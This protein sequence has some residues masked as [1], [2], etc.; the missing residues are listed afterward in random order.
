MPIYE[1]ENTTRD[2]L[3]KLRKRNMCQVCGDKLS[4]FLD[5]DTGK[6]F[7]A[8]SDWLRSHHEGIE[9]ETS[10]YEKEGLASLNIPTR[11]EIMTQD[12]G[13]ETSTAL[14]RLPMSGR[15]TQPEAMHILK[16]VYP[17]VPEDQIIRTAILCRDFGLHPLMKEVY[18]IGFKNKAGGI[19]YS[20]VIG[21][22]ANRK[23][24]ADKKGAY[25]FIDDSP[26]AASKE[27][28]A[29]QYGENSEEG[30]DNLVS[31]CRLK[32]QLGNDAVGF[33]L[34]P[35]NKSPYGTDKGNTP[36][37]MANIRSERQALDRL[38][39]ETLPLRGYE[40]I[41]E[42]Y[43][44]LPDIGKVNT[45]TGEII[46][47]EVTEVADAPKEHWCK[48]HDC[49]FELKAGKYG[50]FYAHKKDGG[51]WCNEKK[52]KETRP[53]P[54]P[55]EANSDQ[56]SEDEP[57]PEPRNTDAIK[58]FNDL[59]KACHEDFKD[60]EGKGMQPDQVISELGVGSQSDISDTPAE[61]YMRI[62]AVRV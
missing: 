60:A 8:C 14:A 59:Y 4:I 58:T 6:A 7:L 44:E 3:D 51:G 20:T 61:C 39:G 34:W 53:A 24:A 49:P 42:A 48:E 52:K 43:A 16:L 35:K 32:G 21:I 29:K 55:T 57:A 33:G 47:A 5:H 30:K 56:A 18:I 26:R 38:P 46:E 25:S 9:R 28:I 31:I 23:M 62:R 1:D 45:G 27:E 36:R 19:D 2:K 12:Y 13:K 15:L 17:N 50:E 37:N 22:A 40:V 11:R 10:R 54:E 41:D